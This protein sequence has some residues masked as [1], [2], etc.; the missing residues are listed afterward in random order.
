MLPKALPSSPLHHRYGSW[1]PTVYWSRTTLILIWGFCGQNFPGLSDC[2]HKHM[3]SSIPLCWVALWWA[4]NPIDSKRWP[5][6]WVSHLKMPT[7]RYMMQRHV[8]RSLFK[9]NRYEAPYEM[10]PF[11][12]ALQS[13]HHHRRL[14]R[15]QPSELYLKRPTQRTSLKSIQTTMDD[16]C[17]K[18]VQGSG[19]T[20]ADRFESGPRDGSEH[21]FLMVTL[22]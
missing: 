13:D 14:H 15:D 18:K 8:V 1:C 16:L 7:A 17:A 3:P 6:S 11:E 19:N 21:V 10:D 4:W 2:G 12:W 20:D 5:K 9:A 22:L